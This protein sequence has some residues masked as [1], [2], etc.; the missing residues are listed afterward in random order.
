MNFRDIKWLAV[1]GAV[2][3]VSEILCVRRFSELSVV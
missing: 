1:I 3:G 2:A